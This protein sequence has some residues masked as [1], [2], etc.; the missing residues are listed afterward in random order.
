M[1]HTTSGP[2]VLFLSVIVSLSRFFPKIFGKN[3]DLPLDFEGS[4]A[5]FKKLTEE[6]IYFDYFFHFFAY[7]LLLLLFM[8]FCLH[9]TC[10]RLFQQ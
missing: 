2:P 7:L 4:W 3:E 5:A 8:L 10:L 6:V 1:T 9:S